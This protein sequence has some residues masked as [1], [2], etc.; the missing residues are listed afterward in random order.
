MRDDE[1]DEFLYKFISKGKF[2]KNNP[3]NNKNL[4]EEGTLYVAKLQ[5][6][7]LSGNGEW[8]E[9]SYG[10]N[11]LDAKNGF[12]SQADVLINARLAG[13]IVGATP[14][15]RPEWITVDPKGEFVYATLTKK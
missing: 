9:L 1:A 3:K 13:T 12:H 6:E 7:N 15:D 8:I 14:M 4:L 10:K 11:G 5:G 2:D